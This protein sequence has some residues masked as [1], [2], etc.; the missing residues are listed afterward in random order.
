MKNLREF[1]MKAFFCFG[2]DIFI[3]CT[4]FLALLPAHNAML[5]K[6]LNQ[7]EN[8]FSGKQAA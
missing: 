2:E 4:V 5:M 6:F 7:L 1:L 3:G 8:I